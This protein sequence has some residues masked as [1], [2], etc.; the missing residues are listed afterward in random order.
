[1]SI[2][3]TVLRYLGNAQV[4]YDLVGHTPTLRSSETARSAHVST[5]HLA[6]AVV[7]RDRRNHI[8]VVAALPADSHLELRWL[9]EEMAL[10]L[11]MV[12]EADLRTLFPDCEP[13]AVPAF[14]EAYQLATI[15]D[16]RLD[17][18]HDLYFEAGDHRHLIHLGSEGFHR[19]SKDQPHA[20][21][22]TR[23]Q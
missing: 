4:S 5:R 10:D 16:Q 11:E 9:K 6:K 22:S 14:G 12:Q 23:E 19:I 2:P 17:Q 8:P 7:L 18:E 15:W 3:G 20:I 21:I 13:G 1:M